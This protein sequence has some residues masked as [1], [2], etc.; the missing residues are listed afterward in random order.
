MSFSLIQVIRG[1][2]VP[3]V[4]HSTHRSPT[5]LSLLLPRVRVV[6]Y[7]SDNLP[8]TGIILKAQPDQLQHL[9]RSEIEAQLALHPQE[10]QVAEVRLQHFGQVLEPQPRR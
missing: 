3:S 4:T 8:R 7:L 1:M 2:C 6:G 5:L 10:S 9:I